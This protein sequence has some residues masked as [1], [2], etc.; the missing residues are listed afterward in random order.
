MPTAHEELGM[1]IERHPKELKFL[2]LTEM[3]ERFGF[4]LMLGIFL[5]Y[6]TDSEKGGLGWSEEKAGVVYGTYIALVYF[7]PFI[8]GL[9]ADRVLGYRRTIVIGAVLM[10]LGYFGLALP[11]ELTFFIALGLIILG[12]GAFKPNISSLLGNLYPPG[13]SLKEAGYNIFYMGINIGAFICN[14]VAAIVRNTFDRN[15][16]YI[17]SAKITGWQLAFATAGLGMILGLIIFLWAYRRLTA[18]DPD[19]TRAGGN[20]ESL[21]PLWV[22]CIGPALGLAVLGWFLPQIYE[23]YTEEKF[24]LKPDVT[25]FILACVPVIVFYFN[26]WRKVADRV[27]RGRVAALLVIF[28]V[29]IMFWAIFYLNGTALTDFTRD[30]TNRVPGTLVRPLT[31]SLEPLAEDAPPSYFKNAD[32]TLPRPAKDTFRVVDQKE[33]ERRQKANALTEKK[34]ERVY[35]Y[36]TPKLFQQVFKNTNSSSPALEEGEQLK[37]ANTE[38]FQSINPGLVVLLT[39]LVVGFWA[40]LRRRGREPS[41]AAKIGLGLLLTAGGPLVMLAAT[42]ASQDGQHK[43]SAWWLFGTYGML[44]VGELCLSPMGLALVNKVAPARIQAFMMGGW[45]L[46]TSLGGK[47]SGIFAQI[48]HE[49]DREAFWVFLAGCALVFSIIIFLLLPWLNRQMRTD[50]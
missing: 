26:V 9:L 17:G 46:S 15:P 13:S 10:M 5:L 3:W 38:L 19:H 18:A 37:L 14:F 16:V 28:L 1:R 21:M 45:F 40:M 6:M 11:G 23:K 25:A 32:P 47:L 43:V 12:N 22:Q 24:L 7:T 2:F 36:V 30:D 44:T 49:M 4:Y 50:Q 8:G 31:E 34:G 27:E 48:Y 20:S 29:V 39:P 35:V 33:Y 41:T 42:W